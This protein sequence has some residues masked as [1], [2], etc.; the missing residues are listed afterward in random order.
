MRND[1]Q[2]LKQILDFAQIDANIRAIVMNGL[3]VNPNISHDIFCDY[4][5]A[6]FVHDLEKYVKDKNWMPTFGELVIM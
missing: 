2:V 6:C 1:E 4:D 5:F 3:R